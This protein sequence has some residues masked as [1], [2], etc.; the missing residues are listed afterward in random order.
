MAQSQKKGTSHTQ[1]KHRLKRI[2][3]QI[4][5]IS[6]MV[7]EQRYCIDIL[8]QIKAVKSAMS[9]L[10]QNII[11][12]HLDHCVHKAVNSKNKSES[13]EMLK[14]IKDLLKKTQR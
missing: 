2:E 9:G 10:E 4:R 14:E 11:E 7:E 1:Q 3:G 8:T 12:Q 13:N 5:G 6:K